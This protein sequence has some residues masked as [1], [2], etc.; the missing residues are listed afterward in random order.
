M[1]GQ[2]RLVE[3]VEQAVEK[4]YLSSL[5]QKDWELQTLEREVDDLR[6]WSQKVRAKNRLLRKERRRLRRLLEAHGVSWKPQTQG[7][8][9]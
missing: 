3:A 1:F 8:D 2:K 7:T 5:R 6:A 9:T 4:T